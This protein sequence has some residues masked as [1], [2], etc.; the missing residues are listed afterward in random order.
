MDSEV[1]PWD[2]GAWGEHVHSGLRPTVPMPA[3]RK[4]SGWRARPELDP[5]ALDM[6]PLTQPV[7]IAGGEKLGC[8]IKSHRGCFFGTGGES[9]RKFSTRDRIYILCTHRVDS[10][11]RP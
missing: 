6:D 10:E 7:R 9:L 2:G 8:A 5:K 4:T 11:V 1:R 3:A